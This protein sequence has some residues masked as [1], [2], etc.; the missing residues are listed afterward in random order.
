[1]RE[2]LL[3]LLLTWKVLGKWIALFCAG[4]I[5]LWWR[6]WRRNS[7]QRAKEGWPSV[8]GRYLYGKVASVPKT[9]KYVVTLRYSYY[10]DEFRSG[11]YDREFSREADADEFAC[12][13]KDREVQIRYKTSNPGVSCPEA[14]EI[15]RFVLAVASLRLENSAFSHLA[16]RFRPSR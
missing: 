13:V 15:E 9:T 3:W 7:R 6:R 14:D 1:L 10:V 12:E 11:T 16:E 8:T 4:W 2:I 5:G